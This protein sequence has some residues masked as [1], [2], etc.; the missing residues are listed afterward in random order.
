MDDRE[1]DLL[2]LLAVLRKRKRIVLGMTACAAVLSVVISLLLP[3]IYSAETR[4]LPPQQGG[5]GIAGQLLTQLGPLAGLAGLATGVKSPNELYIGML[6][7]RTV[8]DRILDRFDLMQLYDE[9]FR[10]DARKKLLKNVDASS[11]R[12][13]GI[14]SVAVE[15][16]DPTRAA[17]MANAFVEELRVLLSGLAVTEAAQRRLFFEEQLKGARDELGKAEDDIRGFMEKTGAL[18]I[19]SQARAVI[20]GI[21]NLRAQIAAREVQLKVLQSFATSRNPDLQRVQEEIRGLKEELAKLEGREGKGFDPLMPTG[22]MPA[23]GTE[24]FRKFREVKYY[25]TLFEVLAKQYE[26]ARIDEARDSALIQ[27]I[28]AAVPPERKARPKRTVIVLLSTAAALVLS[29][30]LVFMLESADRK[31]TSSN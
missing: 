8:L 23:V 25:E 31:A 11:D 9:E 26:L 13:S 21:A 5:S 24:Y 22:R 1:I 4:I 30:I 28:D 10:E 16:R 6:T 27:V 12:R 2:D 17:E 15:D 14:I 20:E 7:S 18:Q 29:I 3:K 19:D